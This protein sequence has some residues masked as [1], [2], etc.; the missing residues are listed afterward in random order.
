MSARKYSIFTQDSPLK[1][2]Y[3]TESPKGTG[4]IR[5]GGLIVEGGLIYQTMRYSITH[6]TLKPYKP[7]P[8]LY[9]LPEIPPQRPPLLNDHFFSRN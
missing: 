2:Y 3:Y 7:M 9:P 5:V 8:R 4:L 6:P 1:Y